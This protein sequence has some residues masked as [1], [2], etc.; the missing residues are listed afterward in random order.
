[1]IDSEARRILDEIYKR[2]REI[3]ER[4]R[5]PLARISGELIRKETLER[6]ELDALVAAKDQ[7]A[8]ES[9][10]DKSMVGAGRG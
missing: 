1:M 8:E 5:G 9:M 2:V 7:A 6:A 10:V 3:L 4:C